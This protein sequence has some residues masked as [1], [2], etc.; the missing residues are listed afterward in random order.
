MTVHDVV[1]TI[2][3][4]TMT[5]VPV[6]RWYVEHRDNLS[7]AE[8]LASIANGYVQIRGVSYAVES[9]DELCPGRAKKPHETHETSD[10]TCNS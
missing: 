6:G 4:G 1:R 3:P 8:T 9:H 10:C 7:H 5:S 2:A